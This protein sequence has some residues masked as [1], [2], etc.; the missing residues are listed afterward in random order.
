MNKLHSATHNTTTIHCAAAH[1]YDVD[2]ANLLAQHYKYI[3]HT[4]MMATAL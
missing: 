1:H 3:L 2:T 4:V